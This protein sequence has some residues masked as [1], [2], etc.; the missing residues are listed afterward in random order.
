VDLVFLPADVDLRF[1]RVIAALIAVCVLL[2]GFVWDLE[3]D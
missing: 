3:E 1:A 2:F